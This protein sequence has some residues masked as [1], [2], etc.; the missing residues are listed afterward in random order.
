[1]IQIPIFHASVPINDVESAAD[2]FYLEFEYEFN[3]CQILI[4]YI[5]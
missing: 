5:I 2:N 4:L 1:M 3:F